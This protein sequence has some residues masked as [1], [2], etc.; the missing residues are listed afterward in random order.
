MPSLGL[1]HHELSNPWIGQGTINIALP[2][3]A[4]TIP[5]WRGTKPE[6][7]VIHEAMKA[8]AL[9]LRATA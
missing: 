3:A 1:G 6:A 5:T 4:A 8:L 9:A 2:L 7:E